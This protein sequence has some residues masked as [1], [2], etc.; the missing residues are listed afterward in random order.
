MGIAKTSKWNRSRKICCMRTT[1]LQNEATN[2]QDAAR[3]KK[4]MTRALEVSVD[5]RA[6]PWEK[7]LSI[8]RRKTWE[9]KYRLF[10]F[11]WKVQ[12][13][14]CFVM[15]DNIFFF[16]KSTEEIAQWVYVYV[17]P[18]LIIARPTAVIL[19]LLSAPHIIIIIYAYFT[20]LWGTCCTKQQR[21]FAAYKA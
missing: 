8:E 14:V 17:G 3:Q 19:T 10:F 20:L 18:A 12:S 21:Q 9:K 1:N 6:S 11:M 7:I 2:W 15:E 4:D 16:V 5:Y 13:D